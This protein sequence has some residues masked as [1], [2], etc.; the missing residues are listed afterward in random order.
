MS[1]EK[2]DVTSEEPKKPQERLSPFYEYYG[3]TPMEWRLRNYQ[4]HVGC[5]DW[6]QSPW[7]HEW[8]DID[9]K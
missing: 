5:A 7:E 1:D 8:N 3:Y 6:E 9:E 2:E 4:E